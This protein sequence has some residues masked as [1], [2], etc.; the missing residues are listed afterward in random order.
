MNQV[1]CPIGLPI[2]SETPQQI[3]VSV[4]A[5]LLAVKGGM[6]NQRNLASA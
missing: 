3:A 2:F 1:F 6:G 5:Q 4:C